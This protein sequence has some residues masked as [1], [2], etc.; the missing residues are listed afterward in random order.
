MNREKRLK[1][2][3]MIHLNLG[4][5]LPSLNKWQAWHWAKRKR[6]KDKLALDLR[7]L[8]IFQSELNASNVREL[9]KLHVRTGKRLT[10]TMKRYYDGY[11]MKRYD[12]DN[13]IGGCSKPLMDA[14]V[15]IG[16]LPE[17]SDKYLLH[18]PHA[19]KK[20]SMNPRF[21]VILEIPDVV[22]VV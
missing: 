22:G 16:V 7:N 20:D 3:L 17:D 14:L 2:P 18:G 10:V 11:K 1:V 8:I 4:Q 13:F 12:H 21:E 19:Q 5:D 6:L 15:N 9:G